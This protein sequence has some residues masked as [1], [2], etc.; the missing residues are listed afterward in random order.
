[1]RNDGRGARCHGRVPRWAGVSQG[2]MP[3][4]IPPWVHHPP[5]PCPGT[6]RIRCTRLGAPRRATGLSPRRSGDFR[7]R[8]VMRTALVVRMTERP[9]PASQGRQGRPWD[10]FGY[11]QGTLDPGLQAWIR[12]SGSWKGPG[13]GSL[14]PV[15]RRSSR[16]YCAMPCF[17]QTGSR[18]GF[19]GVRPDG[20][21]RAWRSTPASEEA[22]RPPTAGG[23]SWIQLALSA[24]Q[25]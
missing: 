19:P 14:E 7:H 5:V 21:N 15:M 20:R 25:S 9:R 12:G 4:G 6:V 10:V 22:R 23:F 24:A 11:N 1:M 17:D 13:S 16:G 8:I 3:L 18:R 2:G